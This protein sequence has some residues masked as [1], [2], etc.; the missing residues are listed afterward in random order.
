MD[1]LDLE[2][3]R[4]AARVVFERGPVAFAYLFGSTASGRRRPDSDIDIAVYVEPPVG[5]N[6]SLDLQL[7]LGARLESTLQQGEVDLI[8]LNEAPLALVG[9]I[10]RER[11][12]IYCRDEPARVR[13]ESLAF[14]QFCDFDYHA[15]GLDRQLLRAIAEGRR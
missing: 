12:V 1:L 6:Q 13:F 9:R 10:L 3:L 8:V 14:R 2:R 5:P 11:I 15:A 4:R 7:A